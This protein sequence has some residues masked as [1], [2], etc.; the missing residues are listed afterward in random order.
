MIGE[1]TFDRRFFVLA[2]SFHGATLLAKLLNAH[3][4]VVCLGDT[5]PSHAYDQVCGC[6]RLVSECPFWLNIGEKIGAAR[7]ADQPE[8]LPSW[9]RLTGTALDGRLYSNLPIPLLRLLRAKDAGVFLDDYDKFVA[10]VYAQHLGR[11]PKVFIDGV[12]SL[13]RVKAFVAS[14]GRVDGVLHVVRDAA[15][16]VKSATKNHGDSV[17]GL[18]RNAFS[19]RMY[20]SRSSALRRYVPY[21]RI[22]YDQ[23]CDSTDE[24]LD[25]IFRFLGVAPQSVAE[26]RT[27]F[28]REWHFMGNSSMFHFDGKIRQ[29]H[30]ATTARERFVIDLF[31]GRLS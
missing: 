27:N 4:K 6:G 11:D 31:A 24:T 1:R 29:S 30:H 9:P 18:A 16:Y 13:A 20:H 15:D 17:G 7:Y 14:G 19:W 5:Y 3:P 22:G 26:L 23:L 21:L 10:A 8:L 2:P 12:K 28:A 25:S